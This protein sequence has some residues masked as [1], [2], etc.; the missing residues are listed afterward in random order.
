M[1]SNGAPS[2]HRDPEIGPSLEA[3]LAGD[4]NA[5]APVVMVMVTKGAVLPYP[6]LGGAVPHGR[7]PHPVAGIDHPQRG[8]AVQLALADPELAQVRTAPSHLDRDRITATRLD[9]SDAGEII[10]RDAGPPQRVAGG[11]LGGEWRGI[12]Q[13]QRKEESKG[14]HRQFLGPWGDGS[15]PAAAPP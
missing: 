7:I 13:H 6:E 3:A 1:H 8:P 10:E 5:A 9:V 12:E 15:G 4:A 14:G 11:I 2:R